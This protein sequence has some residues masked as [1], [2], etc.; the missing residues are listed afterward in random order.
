LLRCPYCGSKFIIDQIIKQNSD[1]IILGYIKCNCSRFPILDGILIL[2]LGSSLDYIIS[3]IEHDRINDARVVASFKFNEDI[4]RFI[5]ILKNINLKYLGETLALRVFHRCATTES[6]FFFDSLGDTPFDVYLKHRFSLES[7]WSL[8]PFFNVLKSNAI[9]ADLCCGAGHSSYIFSNMFSPSILYAVD[10]SFSN[11]M[12]CKRFFAPTADCICADANYPLPF[13]SRSIDFISI[14][15]AF[16]YIISKTLLAG[17]IMRILGPAGTFLALHLHNSLANNIAPGKPLSPSCWAG[18]FPKVPICI[19]PERQIINDFLNKNELDLLCKYDENVLN[20]SNAVSMI[21]SFDTSILKKYNCHKEKIFSIKANLIINPIYNCILDGDEVILVRKYLGDEF[22]LEFPLTEKYLPQ[23]L[24]INR[25]VYDY[26]NEGQKSEELD[27]YRDVQEKDDLMNSVHRVNN[28]LRFGIILNRDN[29][30]DWENRCLNEISKLGNICLSVFIREYLPPYNDK[31]SRF[32][33]PLHGM[34]FKP[35]SCKMANYRFNIDRISSELIRSEGNSLSFTEESLEIIKRYELDFIIN[36]GV[37]N[38]SGNLLNLPRFGVWAFYRRIME[39]MLGGH[40]CGENFSSTYLIRQ[41]D[42]NRAVVLKRANYLIWNRFISKNIDQSY[43]D[44]SLLIRNICINILDGNCSSL[45]SPSIPLNMLNLQSELDFMLMI[46]IYSNFIKNMLKSFYKLLFFWEQ[47]NIGIVPKPITFFLEQ[48]KDFHVHWFRDLGENEAIADPFGIKLNN[49]IYIMFEIFLRGVLNGNI[50]IAKLDLI[51]CL[52][53]ELATALKSAGVSMNSKHHLSYPFLFSDN[54]HIYCI[55][56]S[57]QDGEVVLYESEGFPGN[58]VKKNTILTGVSLVDNTAF[59]YNNMWWLTCSDPSSHRLYIYYTK[60]ILGQWIAH[61]QNPV[62][63]DI[64]S[65][66]PGGTPFIYNN[67]LYR[68]AQDCS[69]SYGGRIVINKVL[70]L[71]PREFEEEIA[72]IVEPPKKWEYNKGIHTLS[73]VD[74]FTII[75]AKSSRFIGK[76]FI[77][78]IMLYLRLNL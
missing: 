17:E 29:L 22:R 50:N 73:S 26:I 55:P 11:L 27:N 31:F 37:L 5:S 25:K 71:T 30:M 46:K 60:N 15:D 53:D 78:N 51:N 48:N 9:I 2:K 24:R 66:R 39:S 74:N 33:D 40:N 7:F 32:N 75:D 10:G 44:S 61:Y 68:P 65:S 64:T 3:L 16:H 76:D 58:W 54:G 13:K 42:F 1:D 12:K 6:R 4:C 72:S 56:E 57:S 34:L 41:C 47:W 49:T 8:Y 38:I 18:L 21:G 19:M 14:I 52:D 43:Q 45:Y 77:K 67:C 63:I 59:K 35:S 70:K 36:F 20:S 28:N 62:K 23:Q 69:N